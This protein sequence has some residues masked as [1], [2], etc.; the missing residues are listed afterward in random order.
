[1]SF[2]NRKVTASREV[3]I[4]NN[5]G[6]HARPCSKF[7]KLASHF[8]SEVWVVKDDQQVNGKSILGLMMLA[9][10]QGSKLMIT[11]EGADAEEALTALEKLVLTKFDEE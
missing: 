4:F 8:K 6:L 3:E 9:A 10:G 1:M 7:V 11:C 2:L 5:K